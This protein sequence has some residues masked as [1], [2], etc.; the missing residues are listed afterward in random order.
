MQFKRIAHAIGQFQA[1]FD[2][3]TLLSPVRLLATTLSEQH[4]AGI[5]HEPSRRVD[6]MARR[7][8]D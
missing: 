2:F 1:R 5:H 3:F 7:T 4:A 8:A 6:Q